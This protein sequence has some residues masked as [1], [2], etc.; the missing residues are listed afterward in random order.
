MLI[1]ILMHTPPWVWALLIGLIALCWS[2]A[3][4]R[5][6]SLQRVLILPAV[7]GTL[8]ALGLLSAFG[9]AIA[10]WAAWLLG[11]LAAVALV[12]PL[13]MVAGTRWQAAERRFQ[14][15]GSWTP[16]L[17][18]LGIFLTKYAVGVALAMQPDLARSA[19]FTLLVSGLYGLFSGIFLARAAKLWRLS[20]QPERAGEWVR[21]REQRLSW[22]QR[23]ALVLAVLLLTPVLLLA[24]LIGLG[25]TD[26]PPP[27]QAMSKMARSRGYEGLPALGFY[28]AR[29]GARLAYR[30]YAA[31]ADAPRVAVLVHG[32][33]GDSHAM[34]A[35]GRA[36]QAQGISAYALDM[37]G[38]GAS[39]TRGDVSYT[40]QLDDDLADLM[41]Q[42]RVRHPQARIS[43][44]G[45]SS[46]GGFTLRSAGGA[47]R[48]LFESYVLLAPFLHNDAPTTRPNAGG[49]VKVAVP[50]IIGLSLLDRLGLHAFEG[51][52]V[53]KFALPAEASATHTTSYSY[54]LQLS[55]RPHADYLA[56]VRGITRPVRVLVGEQDEL[57]RAE[58][59]APLLEPQQPL[60]K[61]SVLPGV[62]HLGMVIDPAALQAMVSAL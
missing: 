21:S 51:L 33:S 55:Y 11:A 3:R 59:Y 2:Q 40:G 23:L 36:L 56:D 35:V 13:R 29:D 7:M 9:V 5:S 42:L 58:Q 38:H 6:A 30:H 43:L 61:V 44:V 24:G 53:L 37:R 62:N 10:A 47:N 16:M 17:L 45:H 60:L 18:I 20:R 49:W 32:S 28:T 50:R 19:P 46:G 52:P 26:A 8:S 54:R 27:L 39:G 25:G 34:H 41:A 22:P 4:A 57:F 12:L 1:Q 15:P 31:P 14:L 48:D